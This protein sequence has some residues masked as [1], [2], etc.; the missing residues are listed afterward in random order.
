VCVLFEFSLTFER[1]TAETAETAQQAAQ[2]VE[3]ETPELQETEIALSLRRKVWRQ[4]SIVVLNTHTQQKNKMR[5]CLFWPAQTRVPDLQAC[6]DKAER[7][8]RAE[9]PERREQEE[10][11]VWKLLYCLR[12]PFS[13]LFASGRGGHGGPSRSDG[14]GHIVVS[15]GMSGSSGRSGNARFFFFLFKRSNYFFRISWPFWTFWLAGTSRILWINVSGSSMR[16]RQLCRLLFFFFFFFLFHFFE[17][18]FSME[19][20]LWWRALQRASTWLWLV[21]W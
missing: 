13:S 12:F 1:E 19:T 15:S 7:A 20:D 21:I 11:E 3:A 18:Q 8:E 14:Q 2:A 5:A 4:V 10:A 16:K 17:S 6:P 9:P